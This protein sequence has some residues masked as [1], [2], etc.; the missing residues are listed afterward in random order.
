[1]Q[2]VYDKSG[3]LITAEQVQRMFGV[4]RST[5]YRMAENGR[6]PAM[7]IGRQWRFQAR[8]IERLLLGGLPT[9]AGHEPGALTSPSTQAVVEIAADLLGVMM[10]VTDMQGEPVTEMCNPCPWFAARA[11]DEHLLREC[12]LEWRLLAEELDLE[13]R[14]RVGEHGFE[15]ARSY[16]RLDA[17]LVGMVLAGG[18]APAGAEPG[19]GLF[20]L[21]AAQRLEVL[22]ALPKVSLVL[23]RALA[24][25][26]SASPVTP[27]R[28]LTRQQERYD[29]YEDGS[30]EPDQQA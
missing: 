9:G 10:V 28:R 23:S 4:D 5:V 12:S 26:Q 24:R 17:T 8:A 14:F 2:H 19:D 3:T 11:H 7:K 21:E 22:A 16:V 13:P 1:M 6:L 29:Q 27:L 20:H 30:F 18:V 25:E 15:C